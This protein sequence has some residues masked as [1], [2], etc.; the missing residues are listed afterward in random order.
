MPSPPGMTI[1]EVTSMRWSR[2]SSPRSTLSSTATATGTLLTLY[3][4]TTV[5]TPTATAGTPPTEMEEF[6]TPPAR[7]AARR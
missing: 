6:Q 1:A 3:A 7:P 2:A 4:C 5:S